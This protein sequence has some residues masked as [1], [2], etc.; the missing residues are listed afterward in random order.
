M[1]RRL[2]ALVLVLCTVL[3]MFENV[4]YAYTD[5]NEKIFIYTQL[6]KSWITKETEATKKWN[7][8]PLANNNHMGHGGCLIFAYVHAIQW[9]TGERVA[10]PYNDTSLIDSLIKEHNRPAK[11]DL[12]YYA[13]KNTM[14]SRGL[15]QFKETVNSNTIKGLFD[16]GRV[17]LFRTAYKDADGKAK[18]GHILIAVDYTERD[19]NNDGKNE[20]LIHLVDS[21]ARSTYSRFVSKCY[22]S[23]YYSRGFSMYNFETFARM[24][25]PPP[26]TGGQYWVTASD[27]FKGMDV[28]VVLGATVLDTIPRIAVAKSNCKLYSATSVDNVKDSLTNG[29]I[30]YIDAKAKEGWYRIEGGGY[31]R[32]DDVEI[33]V[34][35]ATISDMTGQSCAGIV[36][37][38]DGYLKDKPYEAAAHSETVKKGK[39][40]SIKGTVT[41]KHGNTWYVTDGGKYIYSGDV[42]KFT[43]SEL[44]TITGNFKV[45]RSCKSKQMPTSSS[46]NVKSLSKGDKVEVT[47]FV[48][49]EYG[50]IWAQLKDGS[51]VHFCDKGSTETHLTYIDTSKMADETSLKYQKY[52]KSG[53]KYVKQ[54]V[55]PGNLVVNSTTGI[56][57]SGTVKTQA[58]ILTVVARVA[59][60]K[61]Q[62][63]SSPVVT[64]RPPISLRSFSVHTATAQRN[65]GSK[66]N[67]TE[68]LTF[69]GMDS[70]NDAGPYRFELA[71]QLGFEYGGKTY[72][73]GSEQV[74][75]SYGFYVGKKTSETIPQE[76]GTSRRVPGDVNSDGKVNLIDLILLLRRVNRWSVAVNET[77]ADVNGD[78]AVNLVDLIMLLR[79]IF[80]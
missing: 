29:K 22:T 71:V 77:N 12:N 24:K 17:I 38:N 27:F 33:K 58:P 6:D 36:V 56:Y 79:L 13:D 5:A 20:L 34:D 61:N 60:G 48:T 31:V 1:G 76:P 52:A 72:K 54:D 37:T 74:V 25:E 32:A 40:V 9:L 23:D 63:L 26:K 8:I 7:L 65:G 28:F 21:A 62:V 59:N 14:R 53:S 66:V 42:E 46:Q 35:N 15:C 41:N 78:G 73:L 47:R 44:F 50:N 70:K 43:A 64:V 68:A 80:R 55:T 57:I 2:V 18:D 30:L 39:T 16:K 75:D 45:T 51:Y 11:Q 10:D 69:R 4:A 19:I 3:C 49:N 67:I